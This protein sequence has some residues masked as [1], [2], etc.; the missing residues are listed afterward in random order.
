MVDDDRPEDVVRDFIAWEN[1]DETKVDVVAESIDMYNPGLPEGVVHDRERYANYLH[2]VHK[3]FPDVRFEINDMAVRD[4]MV[5]VE[6]NIAGTHTGEFKGL[7]PTGRRVE[8]QA[9]GKWRV[10]DGEVVE[11]HIYYDTTVL[12]E[13]LGLTF[14]EVIGQ[15]PKLVWRKLQ[16]S[17]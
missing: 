15:A 4:D 7:P 10:S 13:Q 5:M 12:P 11:C 1:G 14:P 3:G 6:V 2:E 17:L 9:M 8:F 16:A